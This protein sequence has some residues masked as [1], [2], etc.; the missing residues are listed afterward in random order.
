MNN[1]AS[2]TNVSRLA[3][4]VKSVSDDG[5]LQVVYYDNGVGNGTD[6]LGQSVDG[7]T[8]RGDY[9]SLSISSTFLIVG[10]P[11][12]NKAPGISPKIRNA[13]S[14][15]S[16]NYNFETPGDQIVLVGFSRGAFTVQCLASLI[17]QI[18]LLKKTSLG[19]LRGLYKLWSRQEQT[20]RSSYFGA[21]SET[22]IKL[23]VHLDDELENIERVHR[24][25]TGEHS[26]RLRPGQVSIDVL[27]VWDT[28]SSLG[29]PIPSTSTPRP[30][31]FV[32]RG[33]PRIVRSAFHALAL[34]DS[35][36]NFF[37]LVWESSAGSDE[38]TRLRD[39][40]RHLVKQCW[41]LG[42]HGNVGG[43]R[44]DAGLSIISFMWMAAQMESCIPGC[45]DRSSLKN[46]ADPYSLAWAV[47]VRRHA[48][49]STWRFV[50]HTAA[51]GKHLSRPS[52]LA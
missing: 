31:D 47:S 27:A 51:S 37:P 46:Y 48:V 29:M 17:D 7:A 9:E 22:R 36:R 13:Y 43:G 21:G 19:F 41:F 4:S 30:L 23:G 10:S 42:A 15:I 5:Y 40:T 39:D 35:R 25:M 26:F 14:F 34:N 28:V 52:M 8:G 44:A 33:I 49:E 20:V 18:G 2:I 11:R 3:R 45:L 24:I 16:H 6:R 12:S 1:A 50:P 32:G 38:G